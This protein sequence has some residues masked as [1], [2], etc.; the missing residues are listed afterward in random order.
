MANGL[1]NK[2]LIMKAWTHLRKTE[3]TIPDETLDFM[4][5]VSLEKCAEMEAC[6]W[7]MADTGDRQLTI[8]VVMESQF[9]A[10]AAFCIECD[11]QGLKPLKY[12][13]YLEIG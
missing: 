10:Y 12:K 8:P 2:E 11:R 6:D 4:R 1:I 3:M 9:E 13:D 5:D 7:G